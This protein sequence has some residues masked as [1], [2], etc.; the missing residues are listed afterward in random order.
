[1]RLDKQKVS[2]AILSK[3]A[4]GYLQT[5]HTMSYDVAA[6]EIGISK[7]TLSRVIRR[8]TFDI[9][10][11]LKICTWLDNDVNDFIQDVSIDSKKQYAHLNSLAFH[12]YLDDTKVDYLPNGHFTT[13]IGNVDLFWLGV[14][15]GKHWE[16]EQPSND[17]AIFNQVT[18]EGEK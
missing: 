4:I 8:K 7:P 13:I 1:M 6:K 5:G 10:T 18:G 17:T 2:Q 11:W 3:L 15:F 12:K 14:K 16:K 9:D